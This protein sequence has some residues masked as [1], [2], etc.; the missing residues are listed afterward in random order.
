MR[1]AGW[2]TRLGKLE[3]GGQDCLGTGGGIPLAEEGRSVCA[4]GGGV[5][6]VAEVVGDGGKEK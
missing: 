4:R 2:T 3:R 6:G 1:G 5:W